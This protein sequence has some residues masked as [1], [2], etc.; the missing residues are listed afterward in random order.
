MCFSPSLQKNW[1][2]GPLMWFDGGKMQLST[3]LRRQKINHR[4]NRISIYQKKKC[5]KEHTFIQAASGG[6]ICVYF[7]KETNSWAV[8]N[9]QEE[10]GGH[11]TARI[12]IIKGIKMLQ[13]LYENKICAII[14]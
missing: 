9:F 5:E 7:Q 10:C 1:L 6:N 13:H 11:Y 2:V 14:S 12:I 4:I 8:K 3:Q